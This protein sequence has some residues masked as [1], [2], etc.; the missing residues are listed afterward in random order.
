MD[1]ALLLKN[2]MGDDIKVIGLDFNGESVTYQNLN[3]KIDM[4]WVS[5]CYA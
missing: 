4:I 3:Q 1:N 2:K 5:S